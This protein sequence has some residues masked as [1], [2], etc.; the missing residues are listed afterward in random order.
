M[1]ED[2]MVDV[3]YGVFLCWMVV[4][5]DWLHDLVILLIWC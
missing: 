4:V 3:F 5:E 1:Y 2:V